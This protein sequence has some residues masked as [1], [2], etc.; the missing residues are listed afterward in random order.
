[1]PH[2]LP[3]LRFHPLLAAVLLAASATLAM[4]EGQADSPVARSNIAGGVTIVPDRIIA[5]GLRASALLDAEVYN[6]RSQQLGRVSELIATQREG[7]LRL[8][9][10]DTGGFLD[11]GGKEVA[12]P[13]AHFAALARQFVLRNATRDSLAQYPEVSSERVTQ[14]DDVRLSRLLEA[15]VYNDAGEHLGEVNDLV[16]SREGVVTVVILDVDGFLGLDEHRIAV[17]LQ[18]FRGL[19]LRMVLPRATRDIL[20]DLPPYRGR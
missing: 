15:G 2:S 3:R 5:E 20:R 7:R 13:V 18:Q 12:V 11:I 8:V 19:D 4:A 16:V 6:G 14:Q 9:F 1:M 17:P 10:V